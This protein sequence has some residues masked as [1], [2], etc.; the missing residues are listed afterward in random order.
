MRL[1]TGYVRRTSGAASEYFYFFLFA[2]LVSFGCSYLFVEAFLFCV[3]IKSDVFWPLFAIFGLYLQNI[4]SC[5]GESDD[6][7][8]FMRITLIKLFF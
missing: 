8:M 1:F 7:L 5:L 3:W 4:E 2:L 6:F